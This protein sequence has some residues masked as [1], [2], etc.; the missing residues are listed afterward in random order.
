[1]T[2]KG[3]FDM[4][5]PENLPSHLST[6]P[7]RAVAASTH[8]RRKRRL[9]GLRIALASLGVV[10]IAA[11]GVVRFVV[12]P[13]NNKLPANT[14][15]TNVYAGTAPVLLNT[16]ALAPGSTAPVLLRNLPLQ[17]QE[18]VRVLSSNDSDAVIAY[19]TTE[20]VG[21]KP[22]PALDYRYQ[23]SRTNLG[24]AS[25]L[26]SPGLMP[27]KGL[28]VSF[29]IGTQKQDYTGFV[30]DTGQTTPLRF[31]GTTSQLT[32]AGKTYNLGF[33]AYIFKQTTPAAAITDP[34]VLAMFPKAIPKAEIPRIIASL[35]LPP[36]QLS[37]LASTFAK[38]PAMVPLAYTY[39]STFT[40]WV[41]PTDG[42][43][44]N[45]Q[46]SETRTVGLPASVLGVATPIASVS[47]F[48]YT[49]TA[50]TLT[51]RIDQA[52]HDS[53]LLGL[54]G[55]TLPLVGL[56]TGVVLVLLAGLLGIRRREHPAA[57]IE[58]VQPD[59]TSVERRGAA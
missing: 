16:A 52:R 14:N 33:D 10:L 7:L 32:L 30:R 56:S 13:A 47:Q 43:V 49:D 21:G 53:W 2:P 26:S 57:V 20:A 34:Q 28:T 24:P 40:Y 51:A 42:V 4:E 31:T 44:V 59:T 9:I 36:A 37:Q 46:A 27:T 35:N 29:P 50:A 22:L 39:A 45:L 15:T 48:N 17:I 18:S 3:A 41:A 38:L 23:V 8:Q 6:P 54:V 19:R 25:S 12:L 58:S 11:A 5:T 1:M 55:T